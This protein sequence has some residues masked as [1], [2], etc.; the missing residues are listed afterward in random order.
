MDDGFLRR[1]VPPV[2]GDFEE[3][4]W[5]RLN[6]RKAPSTPWRG[7]KLVALFAVI[8]AVAV[9]C[10]RELWHPH[11]V[12]VGELWVWEAPRLEERE[13]RISEVSGEGPTAS[14]LVAPQVA[15]EM[16]PYSIRLPTDLPEGFALWSD[17]GVVAPSSPM[18]LLVLEWYDAEGERITLWAQEASSSAGEVR[19]PRGAW[20]EVIV[21]G[22]PAVLVR[23]AFPQL[24][25]TLPT[26][27]ENGLA[28][29]RDEWDDSGGLQLA[30]RSGGGYFEL[31]TYGTYV[32][33]KQ[34]LT[35]AES[36]I[37]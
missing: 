29:V 8:V 37:R 15:V 10:A 35:L 36:M 7:G 21:G 5:G 9:A 13:I 26:P 31:R 33:E 1:A 4:L 24:P 3:E 34:L 20:E 27:D 2:R 12:Q 19:A 32:D 17:R 18:W 25:P 11:Y 22:V 6:S 16:L 14:N 30:W 23:G 28:V